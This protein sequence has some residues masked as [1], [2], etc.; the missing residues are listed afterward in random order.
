MPGFQFQTILLHK[1]P[2]GKGWEI[3]GVKH[4]CSQE[5]ITTLSLGTDPEQGEDFVY[6]IVTNLANKYARELAGKPFA[7]VEE[8]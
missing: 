3:I 4:D 6:K 7:E 8:V 1:L 2:E 5:L